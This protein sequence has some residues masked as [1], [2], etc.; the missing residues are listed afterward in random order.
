MITQ[1]QL[2]DIV[3]LLEQAIDVDLGQYH[4]RALDF[5]YLQD[6]DTDTI[7]QIPFLVHPDL[8]QFSGVINRAINTTLQLGMS[9]GRELKGDLFCKRIAI[10]FGFKYSIKHNGSEFSQM[11]TKDAS[12]C[13]IAMGPMDVNELSI[14]HEA[15]HMA[16]RLYFVTYEEVSDRSYTDDI[17]I[18]SPECPFHSGDFSWD[19]FARFFGKYWRKDEQE[20]WIVQS[21]RYENNLAKHTDV[22]IA[23]V[24]HSLLVN[25]VAFLAEY[26]LPRKE[27]ERLAKQVIFNRIHPN[28]IRQQRD[29]VNRAA[30]GQGIRV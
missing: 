3:K 26:G 28:D 29:A 20:Y 12:I 6:T 27:I 25:Y 16:E 2:D 13:A 7:E 18:E 19:S 8:D 24:T 21:Y 30:K 14:W 22:Q 5:S 17:S 23:V 11:A 9:Q 10:G 15:T 4:A 1:E